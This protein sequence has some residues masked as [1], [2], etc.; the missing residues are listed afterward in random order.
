MTV[1]L[2]ELMRKKKN[3]REAMIR[4]FVSDVIELLT[5]RATLR[6]Y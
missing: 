1:K 6:N 3:V 5:K 2:V 4:S